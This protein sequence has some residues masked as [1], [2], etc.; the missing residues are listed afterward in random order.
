MSESVHHGPLGVHPGVPDSPVFPWT[1]RHAELGAGH[2]QGANA[3]PFGRFKGAE[4]GCPGVAGYGLQNPGM[5]QTKTSQNVANVS[6]FGDNEG[7]IQY[8]SA[9]VSQR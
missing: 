2:W 5:E 7:K 9:K 4:M 1:W 8:H 6:I 3:S